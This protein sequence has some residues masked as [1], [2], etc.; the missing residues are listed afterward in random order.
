[1]ATE[2]IIYANHVIYGEWEFCLPGALS[3]TLYQFDLWSP[4]DLSS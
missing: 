4:E 2:R 1:M 3:H